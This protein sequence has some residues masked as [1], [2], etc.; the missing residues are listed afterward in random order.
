[1][2]VPNRS[3]SAPQKNAASPIARKSIVAAADTP[4]RDQPMSCEIG[5]R[6]TASDSID[7]EADA[8]H[9]RADADH[10]P[11]VGRSGGLAHAFPLLFLY[12]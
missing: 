9:Q 2:R 8:G 12:L 10:D 7:A 3:D 5:C 6:N 1:M 4:L 11:A